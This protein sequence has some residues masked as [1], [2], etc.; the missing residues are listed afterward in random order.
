MLAR[1]FQRAFRRRRKPADFSREI[2]SHIELEAE[3]LRAQGLGL[4]EARYAA[5]RAFGNVTRAQERFYQ[6]GRSLLVDHLWQDI[7]FGARMLS[8]SPAFTAVAVLTLALGM[9]AN[10]AIFS[11]VYGIVLK[12]LPYPHA[13]QLVHIMAE[14]TS[15]DAGSQLGL[16]MPVSSGAAQDVENECPAFEA[17]ARYDAGQSFTL[18]GGSAPEQLTA[19]AVDGNFFSFVGVPPLWGRVILPGDT[20]AGSSDVVVLSYDVSVSLHQTYKIPQFCHLVS[21]WNRNCFGKRRPD[22]SDMECTE[23]QDASDAS[24]T[25][26]CLD[27]SLVT[28]WNLYCLCR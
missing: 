28:K 4:E 20:T 1:A 15:G 9:G 7:R 10:T 22:D 18:T 8:K 3:R 26:L 24:Y 5:R 16:L 11:A 13:S 27:S 19:T 6:S 25:F 21:K 14:K 2:E 17:F 23:L 12:P